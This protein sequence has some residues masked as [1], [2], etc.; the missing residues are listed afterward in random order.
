MFGA[1]LYAQSVLINKLS[2][3]ELS[4]KFYSEVRCWLG[5]Y[6]LTALSWTVLLLWQHLVPLK[7]ARKNTI[8]EGTTQRMCQVK[9]NMP[10]SHVVVRVR[11]IVRTSV[12]VSWKKKI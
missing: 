6:I 7:S 9:Y 11:K 8:L 5:S 1:N 12:G 10:T 2:A 3:P 4:L